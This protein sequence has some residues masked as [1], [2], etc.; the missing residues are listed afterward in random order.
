VPA[1]EA[2]VDKGVIPLH[3]L[4]HSVPAHKQDD[5]EEDEDE[6]DDDDVA[7]HARV[8]GAYDPSEFEHLAVEGEVRDLFHHIIQ[9]TPQ[10][11]D[12]EYKFRYDTNF[13]GVGGGGW[14]RKNLFRFCKSLFNEPFI[15]DFIP[16]NYFF[17]MLK[18]LFNRPFIPDFI[19]AVGDI[20]AFIRVPRPDG[21]PEVSAYAVTRYRSGEDKCDW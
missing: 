7:V 6:D 1:V 8:E 16:G 13:F 2:P 11:M 20:D 21:Q 4:R 15:S 3:P 19:P 10:V 9:Y 12:L 14:P 18:I 5:D 17:Q